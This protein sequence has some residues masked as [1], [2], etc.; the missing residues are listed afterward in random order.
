MGRLEKLLERIKRNPRTVRFEEL[1]TI[2]CR[3]GFV[4]SQPR[5]GSSHYIY[6]K[7]PY[8]LVVPY[9][10]PYILQAYVTRAIKLLEGA[11]KNGEEL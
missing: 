8:K 11:E 3:A 1:D 2:L 7:G 4:R 6:R 5:G 10:Q 9:R